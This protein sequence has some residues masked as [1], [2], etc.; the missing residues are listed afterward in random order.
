RFIERV[1][2]GGHA[3]LPALA[4]SEIR[5]ADDDAGILRVAERGRDFEADLD[6]GIAAVRAVHLEV[7][8]ARAE[9]PVVARRQGELGVVRRP[10]DFSGASE[11]AFAFQRIRIDGSVE[12]DDDGFLRGDRTF[13][14]S[15]PADVIGGVTTTATAAATTT[16]TCGR[17][18]AVIV[19]VDARSN[20]E[21]EHADQE[22][23]QYARQ[24][25]AC[26]CGHVI[27]PG[28]ASNERVAPP[29]RCAGNTHISSAA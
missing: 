9:R 13:H 15:G 12:A 2:A 26:E 4:E 23:L 17:R 10:F 5:L 19:V 16:T 18:S 3:A 22:K 24:R 25:A 20:R 21:G 29:Y 27:P 8:D 1:R 28:S 7:Q 6:V 11:H 14:G